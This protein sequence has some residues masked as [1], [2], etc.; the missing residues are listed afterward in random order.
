VLP[1][2]W[3]GVSHDFTYVIT[4]GAGEAA[5]VAPVAAVTTTSTT[6][7]IH[8]LISFLLPSEEACLLHTFAESRCAFELQPSTGDVP[9]DR[10]QAESELRCDGSDAVSLGYEQH[11]LLLDRRELGNRHLAPP[12][13]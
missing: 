1:A 5:A 7:A 8:F 13:G 9:L 10:L 11:D 2:Q 3:I 12:L 6:N 4:I